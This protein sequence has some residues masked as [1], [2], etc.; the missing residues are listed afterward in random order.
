MK[1]RNFLGLLTA[2]SLSMPNPLAAAERPVVNL[3]EALR[4]GNWLGRQGEGSCVHATMISLFN[5]QGKYELAKWWRANHGDGEWDTD[6]ANKLTKAGVK[7]AYTSRRGDVGFLEWSI[8]TRRGCGVTVMGGRHM[9]ALVHLDK[10]WAGILD[11]NQTGKIIWVKR[12]TFISEWLNS[13]SWAIVP[14]VGPP[15][16]PLAKP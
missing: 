7:F 9:V 2:I 14:I 1:R 8:R 6:L 3:P 11:N 16:P 10:D 12:A 4:Q 5:W 15:M 13:S